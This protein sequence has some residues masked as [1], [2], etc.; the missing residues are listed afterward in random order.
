MQKRKGG[1]FVGVKKGVEEKSAL[2]SLTDEEV[3]VRLEYIEIVSR[4]GPPRRRYTGKTCSNHD[5]CYK[6]ER[7]CTLASRGTFDPFESIV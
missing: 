7:Q 3:T 5:A 4:T 6:K 1:A 2:C